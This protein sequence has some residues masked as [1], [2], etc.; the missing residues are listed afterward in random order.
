MA[1]GWQVL[2]CL[3][4]LLVTLVPFTNQARKRTFIDVKEVPKTDLHVEQTMEFLINKFNEE[5]M[6]PY[7]FRIVRI[8]DIK[9]QITNHME[10]HMNLEMLRTTCSKSETRN[11]TFQEGDLYK[12]I[13]CYFSVLCIPWFERYKILKKNC[14]DVQ[15]SRSVPCV[16][17]SCTELTTLRTQ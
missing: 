7:K 1:C 14:T 15:V 3:L 12:L 11:C 5:S 6:D 17:E 2:W 10:F 8:L 9:M 4:V 13:K 16:R